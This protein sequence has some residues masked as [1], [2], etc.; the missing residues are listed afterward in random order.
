MAEHAIAIPE[1]MPEDPES[2]VTALETAAIFGARGDASEA[3]HW[4]RHAATSAGESGCDA[5]ALDLA[6]A[7]SDLTPSPPQVA[8]RPRT[9]P[10]PPSHPPSAK[11]QLASSAEP[12][13]ATR[14][15]PPSASRPHSPAP[16]VAAAT[17]TSRPP[18]SSAARPA[19]ARAPASVAPRAA[20]SVRPWPASSQRASVAPRPAAAA[21]VRPSANASASASVRPALSHELDRAAAKYELDDAV[22]TPRSV[23]S[24]PPLPK[25]ASA[26]AAVPAP[27]LSGARNAARV[28]LIP[29]SEPGVFLTRVL[30]DGATVPG[31]ALE[32]YVI[33]ADPGA[34]LLPGKD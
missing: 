24:P 31:G 6:R 16:T 22:P 32:G 5:R 2:V 33:L 3:L 21:S 18:A 27:A 17:G 12:R 29:G 1:P 10:A 20:Q 28:C 19:S 25:E 13:P 7:A 4:V 23:P 26:A 34:D 9:L 15:P 11:L 8:E 30:A 14:P